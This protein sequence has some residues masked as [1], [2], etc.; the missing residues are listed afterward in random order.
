MRIDIATLFVDMMKSVL[1]ESIIGR[2]QKA[3]LVELN[4]HNIRDYTKDKHK[5]VDDMPYGGG[6]GMVMQPEPIYSCYESVCKQLGSKPYVVYMSPQG[7]TLTQK[8]ALELS[9]DVDN[10]FILCGHYEGVDERVIDLIVDEEI[11]IGDYVLTG[12]ELPALVLIDSVVRLIPKV[13]KSP[14]CYQDESHFN[15]KLE[16]PQYTRPEVWRGKEVPKVLISGHHKKI[17][18]YK[19]DMALKNTK[20]KRPDL[21]KKLKLN[22]KNKKCIE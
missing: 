19:E 10:L 1:Q 22:D 6:Y 8:R 11:S 9:K 2:A 20:E 5:R 16:H 12:G 15:I 21:Y 4:F 3:G 18:E 7:K 17:L 14:I 13:L